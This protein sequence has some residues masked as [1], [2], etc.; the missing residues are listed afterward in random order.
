MFAQKKARW[1]P[2]RRYR[3]L[4]ERNWPLGAQT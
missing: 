2:Q 3:S 4:A 1:F